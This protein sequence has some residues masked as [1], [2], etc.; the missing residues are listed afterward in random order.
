MDLATTALTLISPLLTKAGE[1]LA[2]KAGEKAFEKL[3]SL[4]DAIKPVFTGDNELILLR[5]NEDPTNEERQAEAAKVLS[6]TL[7][8]D[9]K[10]AAEVER[11]VNE[12][13]SEPGVSQFLTQVYG[14]KVGKIVNIGSA[15]N[16]SF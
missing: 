13:K 4:Y 16:V 8:S 6:Q 3:S 1:S 10:L 12:A 7:D 5:L 11:W 14:G 15:G 2:S 9:P